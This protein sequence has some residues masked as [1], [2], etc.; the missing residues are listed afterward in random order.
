MARARARLSVRAALGLLRS[1]WRIWEKLLL[2]QALQQQEEGCLA[3]KCKKLEK[4]ARTDM[5]R[6]RD[7]TKFGGEDCHM[8][9]GLGTF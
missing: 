7:Y 1:R 8:A 2:V 6:R 9:F 5:K 3:M 4:M